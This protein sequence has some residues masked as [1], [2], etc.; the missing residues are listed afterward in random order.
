[1]LKIII[2]GSNGHMGQNVA[3]LCDQYEDIKVV[4][5]FDISGDSLSRFPVYSSPA[6]YTDEADAV[7]DFSNPSAL[8]PLLRFCTSRMIPAVICTTGYSDAQKEE[9]RIASAQ[10]PVFMSANMSLGINLLASLIKKAASV[11]GE[12]YDVEIFDRDSAL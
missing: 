3:R 8:T 7:I 11:L 9:I 2:S 6:D 10:I 4:A 12:D 5:G 1:M